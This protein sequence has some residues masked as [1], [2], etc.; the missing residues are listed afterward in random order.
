MEKTSEKLQDILLEDIKDNPELITGFLFDDQDVSIILEKRGN[1]VRF[2]YLKTY[3]KET[4]GILDEAKR[5][6]AQKKAQGYTREQA[7]N[8]FMDAR[9]EI[10]K[11]L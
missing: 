11:R 2:A 8:D 9:D 6:Y 5:E 1:I 10:M 4:T 3:D 7:F